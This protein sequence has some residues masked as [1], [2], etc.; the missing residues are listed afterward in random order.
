M[1]MERERKAVLMA[2]TNEVDGTYCRKILE[3][4][5]RNTDIN[6]YGM[7]EKARGGKLH[8][9]NETIAIKAGGKSY[10]DL[11]R[12]V[13]GGIDINK[14]GV[15]IRDVKKSRTGDL[16]LTVEGDNK[17]A[18]TLQGEIKNKL[19]DMK[20]T[21]LGGGLINYI[22]GIDAT[23]TEKE[24]QREVGKSLGISS[25]LVVIRSLKLGKKAQKV[26]TVE[27]PR[28]K[29]YMLTRMGKI[30]IGWSMCSIKERV[31]VARCYN[32][33]NFGHIASECKQAKNKEE[34]CINCGVAGHRA[35][36][37][38]NV[39]YC[40][41]C[42]ESG[43]RLDQ[44][45]CPGFRKAVETVRRQRL[46]SRRGIASRSETSTRKVQS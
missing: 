46:L 13:K 26:A 34:T 32:C 33:L 35:K 30:G 22:L 21:R 5:F 23:V 45:A 27:L 42:D 38:Q 29:S 43:H 2:L 31:P 7:G 9:R 28:D 44:M 25:D 17:M 36:Q 37:C 18:K 11:L 40:P 39:P 20:V 16:L 10:A 14:I 4:V 6:I 15:K 12:E 8:L 24:V 3:Y 1:A 41:K 19:S